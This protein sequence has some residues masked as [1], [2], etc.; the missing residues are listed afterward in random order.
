MEQ[1]C[2]KYPLFSLCGLNCGLC[3]QYQ[4]KSKSKCPGCGGEE[5][6]MKHP[7]C[8]VINCNK[9]HDNIEY[10]CFCSSYPCDRYKNNN[11]DSFIT[12]KKRIADFECIKKEGIESYRKIL[13]RKVHILEFFLD[14]YNDGKR[15]NFY[16]LAVNLLEL[17]DLEDV[18]NKINANKE[19]EEFQLKE[20]IIFITDLLNK[21]ADNRKTE[22]KL[23]K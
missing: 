4:T 6:N 21:K 19:F 10:C 18:L 16:C 15:K 3:P 13:N 1:Y 22:L 14:N 20:K 2:R 9:K 5:F 12:Y 8:P 7:S 17:T 23:R 11:K